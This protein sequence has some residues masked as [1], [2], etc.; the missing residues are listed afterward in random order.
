L[1][2][3]P[4]L[5]AVIGSRIGVLGAPVERRASRHVLGRIFAVLLEALF[6]TG[7]YDSQCGGKFFRRD[8]VLPILPHLRS[9]SWLWDTQ[10]LVILVRRRCAI[11]EIPVAWHEVDGSKVSLL[12]DPFLMF[13][14]LLSF[15]RVLP[16]VL[17][18]LA[19]GG[20]EAQ[21]EDGALGSTARSA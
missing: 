14:G 8:Q 4:E 13:A 19:E 6:S 18:A 10:L 20:A 9:R 5:G 12:S 2:A 3:E 17:K 15:R 1:R 16:G 11:R 7:I 21:A